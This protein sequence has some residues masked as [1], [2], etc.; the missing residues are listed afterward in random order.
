MSLSVKRLSISPVTWFYSLLSVENVWLKKG[1]YHNVFGVNILSQSMFHCSMFVK[2]FTRCFCHSAVIVIIL[3]ISC[4][5]MFLSFYCQYTMLCITFMFL[6]RLS[7]LSHNHYSFVVTLLL[8]CFLPLG[9]HSMCVFL[10]YLLSVF[11][12]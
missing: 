5:F 3:V 6:F 11:D 2:Y 1:C 4:H 9:G 7:L 12:H 8:F 10:L